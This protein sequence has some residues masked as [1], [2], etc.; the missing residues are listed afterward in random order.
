MLCI[1]NENI[2]RNP[3]QYQ[4]FFIS[5][6]DFEGCRPLTGQRNEDTLLVFY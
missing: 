1:N 4:Y 6:P 5:N 2:K 3:G